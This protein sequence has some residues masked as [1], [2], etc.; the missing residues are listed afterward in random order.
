MLEPKARKILVIKFRHIGDVLLTA[1]LISTLKQAHP[2][3]RVSA[4]VKPGTEAMLEGHP[5]LDQLYVLPV[6]AAHESKPYFFRRYLQWLWELRKARFDIAINTTEGDR[7]ILFSFLSGAAIRISLL[8]TE[9]EKWWRR[10]MVNQP[11]LPLTGRHHTVIRNL[12]L[13]APITTKY[14]YRV[15]LSFSDTDLQTIQHL[16]HSEG[17]QKNQPLVH[18]HPTSRW[19]FKCWKDEYMA[20]IIDWLETSGHCVVLTAAP[21]D[22]ELQRIKN[23]IQYC[24]HPPIQLAGK[25]TLKQMAALSS[26]STLFFGVDSAPMHIAAS[27]NIPTI[28]LFGPSGGFDWGPWPNDWNSRQNPYINHNGIQ[29]TGPHI[30]IQKPWE[31]APCGQDGCEGNKKSRCLNE[32]APDEVIPILQQQLVQ[33]V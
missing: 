5:D 13:A 33:I 28:G 9:N 25:V 10:W 23:I 29:Y 26:L 20:E 6:R 2:G 19:L 14:D 3:N 32:L 18:I 17:W 1:P 12:A 16:L 11:T 27:Q 4:A 24:S 7:G 15:R 8:K 31:C 21:V 30:V 22:A